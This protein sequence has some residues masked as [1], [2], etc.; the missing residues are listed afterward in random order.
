MQQIKHYHA[1]QVGGRMISK[2]ISNTTQ[3][4]NAIDGAEG[5]QLS[6]PSILT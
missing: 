3:E 4:F 5:W 1:L 6:S 2:K